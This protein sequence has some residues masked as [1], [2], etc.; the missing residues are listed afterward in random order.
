MIGDTYHRRQE[1]K[2]Y[3]RRSYLPSPTRAAERRPSFLISAI[4]VAMPTPSRGWGPHQT[5]GF[6]VQNDSRRSIADSSFS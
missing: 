4:A 5:Q 2:V 3:V 6:A 1:I